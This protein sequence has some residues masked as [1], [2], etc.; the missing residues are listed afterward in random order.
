MPRQEL[1]LSEEIAGLQVI[2]RDPG[3]ILEAVAKLGRTL[4]VS[5]D[6]ILMA[7]LAV[8]AVRSLDTPRAVLNEHL[9]AAPGDDHWISENLRS[10]I[11]LVFD[12][13]EEEN[14]DNGSTSEGA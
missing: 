14:A 8:R 9:I 5:S 2:S 1:D 4:G 10:R 11:N 13:E 3:E 7:A 12:G 6:Q